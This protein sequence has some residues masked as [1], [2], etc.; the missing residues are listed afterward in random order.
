MIPD[1]ALIAG[2]LRGDKRAWD[3]FVGRFSKLVYWSLRRTLESTALSGRQDVIDDLFQDFFRELIEK[4]SLKALE[5]PAAL[6]RFIVV[7]AG[8]L[9]L[10]RAIQIS[11]QARRSL[12]V[13][14]PGS[15][16]G[17]QADRLVRDE[18]DAMVDAVLSELGRRERACVRLHFL[19]GLS[20]QEIAD[21]LNMD[22]RDTVASVIRRSKS[23]LE[24][25][26]REKG[27]HE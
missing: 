26:M 5:D 14:E 20:F 7:S 9:A 17:G 25:L 4:R 8:R 23:K 15:Q 2:C 3:E 16:T 27:L 6:K 19:E 24:T 11:R 1:A 18:S 12:V 21:R 13:D 10:D 22:S